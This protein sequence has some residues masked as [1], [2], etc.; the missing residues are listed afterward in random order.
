MTTDEPSPYPP[1]Q[2]SAPPGDHPDI[3][4]MLGHVRSAWLDFYD[5]EYHEVVR[6]VM[7]AGASLTDA[8]D[9]AQEAFMDSWTLAQEPV[10]WHT[11]TNPRAW[12]RTVALRK[13]RRPPGPRRTLQLAHGVDTPDQAAPGLDPG[14]LTA[15][16]DLLLHALRG[17]EEDT[18]TVMAFPL[19][20]FLSQTTADLMGQLGYAEI[21]EQKVR[22]LLAKARRHLRRDL[23]SLTEQGGRGNR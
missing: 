13:Y 19:D 17:L 11:I 5:S 4:A 2:P 12:I 10:Q 20:G 16:A 9:A 3:A 1:G 6:F 22:D 18:Q 21:T 7:R 14:E 8:E 15:Q 23:A